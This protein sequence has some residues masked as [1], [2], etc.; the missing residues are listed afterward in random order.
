MCFGD[1]RL[2]LGR[3]A[4]GVEHRQQAL[5]RLAVRMGSPS[6]CHPAPP[7][8]LAACGGFLLANVT[9]PVAVGDVYPFMATRLAQFARWL[10]SWFSDTGRTRS[11]SARRR[12]RS[13]F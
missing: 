12:A 3:P 10:P 2:G 8:I 1:S 6:R 5:A 11:A 9:I 4:A 7:L 13:R